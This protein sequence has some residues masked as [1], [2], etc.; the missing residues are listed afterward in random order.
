MASKYWFLKFICWSEPPAT[1]LG[2][3]GVKRH[4]RDADLTSPEV[5]TVPAVVS[6]SKT[7]YSHYPQVTS[8]SDS[9]AAS[10]MYM[11]QVTTD[12]TTMVINNSYDY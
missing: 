6:K 2:K 1:N 12:L 3:G 5:S 11:N 8:R 9:A 10:T 4:R 7:N